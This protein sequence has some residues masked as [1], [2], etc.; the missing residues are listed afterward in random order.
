MFDSRYPIEILTRTNLKL[1]NSP[2]PELIP[3]I[4]RLSLNCGKL[5][6]LLG[7]PLRVSSGF[8][9]EEVNSAVG[10]SEKSAHLRGDAVDF[11]CQFLSPLQIC[12]RLTVLDAVD[13]LFI[14]QMIYEGTWVHIGWKSIGKPRGQVLSRVFVGGNVTYSDGICLS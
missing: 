10:G 12:K 8:R 2:P 5:E 6:S 11:T 7:N 3:N 9:S 4:E 1:K 14:D 13:E